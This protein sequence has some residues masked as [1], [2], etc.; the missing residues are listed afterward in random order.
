LLVQPVDVIGVIVVDFLVW[1]CELAVCRYRKIRSMNLGR[2][3]AT[4]EQ[5]P[6]LYSALANGGYWQWCKWGIVSACSAC[7]ASI[8]NTM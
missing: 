3:E 8:R 5:T 4:L 6:I 2:R 7:P 1:I